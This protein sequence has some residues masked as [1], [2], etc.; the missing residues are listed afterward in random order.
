MDKRVRELRLT[1]DEFWVDVRL[2][3]LRGRWVA[4]ADTPAGPTL[5]WSS[6]PQ[7]ALRLALEPFQGVIADLLASAPM[8][9]P[10]G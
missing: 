4:S 5:A 3:R 10:I 8:D 2:V 6:S 1:C 9:D 7:E